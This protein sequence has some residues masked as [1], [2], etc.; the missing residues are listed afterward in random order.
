[1]H[2]KGWGKMK[3][4]G[5]GVVLLLISIIMV[6]CGK[7]MNTMDDDTKVAVKTV[8]DFSNRYNKERNASRADSEFD[9]GYFPID[10]SEENVTDVFLLKAKNEENNIYYIRYTETEYSDPSLKKKIKDHVREEVASS[11]GTDYESISEKE[12]SQAIEQDN[13]EKI[14]EIKE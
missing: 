11:N 5:L 3:K 4:Y 14:F 10:L 7:S 12:F 13:V 1:M 8:M 2:V 9:S 6:G